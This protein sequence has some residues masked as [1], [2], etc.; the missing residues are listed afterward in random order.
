MV[1]PPDRIVLEGKMK[2]VPPD[3]YLDIHPDF[4]NVLDVAGP[5]RPIFQYYPHAFADFDPPARSRSIPEHADQP[6]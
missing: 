6:A 4:G 3:P 1:V 2:R 5:A